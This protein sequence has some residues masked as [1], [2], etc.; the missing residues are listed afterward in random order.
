MAESNS[1]GLKQD[2]EK[3]GKFIEEIRLKAV[4]TSDWEMIHEW[5][6]LYKDYV[7]LCLEIERVKEAKEQKQKDSIQKENDKKETDKT[8]KKGPLLKK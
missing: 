8:K 6:T 7:K 2:I 3:V 1:G 4:E 5:M